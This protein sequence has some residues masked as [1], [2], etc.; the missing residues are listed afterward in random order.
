VKND[1]RDEE[2]GVLLDGAVREVAVDT[3][4]RLGGIRRRGST[5]RGV[6]WT[7]IVVA[8]A[9]FVGSIGLTAVA[10]RTRATSPAGPGQI[11]RTITI[12][13]ANG[14]LALPA[15][16]Y[17]VSAQGMNADI[18]VASTNRDA[19]DGLV[20]GCQIGSSQCGWH[21]L[22]VM[23]LGPD[24]AFV[25][26][27]ATFVPQGP[28][29]NSI[30]LLPADLRSASWEDT[31][32]RLGHPVEQVTGRGSDGGLFTI[33]RWVGPQA[34]SNTSDAL[35]G[36]LISLQLGPTPTTPSGAQADWHSY[37]DQLL[38]MSMD[39]PGW[40]DVHP[41]SGICPRHGLI[42]TLVANVPFEFQAAEDDHDRC[43]AEWNLRP[44]PPSAVVVEVRQGIPNPTG[45]VDLPLSLDDARTIPP[46]SFQPLET[47]VLTFQLDGRWWKA[48]VWFGSE[49]SDDDLASARRIIASVRAGD[50]ASTELGSVLRLPWAD[51]TL[52]APSAWYAT[53]AFTGP[54]GISV[55][56]LAATRKD[57]IDGHIRC[58]GFCSMQGVS[59]SGLEP[60]DAFL[61][62]DGYCSGTQPRNQPPALPPIIEP[63]AFSPTEDHLGVPVTSLVGSSS[64]CFVFTIR[65]WIGPEAPAGTI[66]QITKLLDQLA[67]PGS[68][69]T[70][71][72]ETIA[73]DPGIDTE[74]FAPPGDANPEI[75]ADDALAQ[76]VSRAG[77]NFPDDM[78]QQLGLYT[79]AVGDGTYRY[80]DQLA[81]GYS[82]PTGCAYAH[83]PGPSA[84]TRCV[85]WLFLDA[86]TGEMLEGLF[87]PLQ[88]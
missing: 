87:Q 31:P 70:R 56:V 67:I 68:S 72:T 22:D 86:N 43:L 83:D 5:R 14:V 55:M 29:E 47:R 54:T 24:D 64:N 33:R 58:D 30:P 39:V 52:T 6:R 10:L 65:Y 66:D 42:G 71:V 32:G 44:L 46:G 3:D 12:P 69:A 85:F 38:G 74:T 2:V 50:V 76:F 27:M 28:E 21:R 17:G 73:L 49:A 23:R 59:V 60:G 41:F 75:S 77:G 9:V 13:Y 19:L 15:G 53:G 36:I 35:D 79:A 25:E 63:R 88:P 45:S 48:T 8:L 57:V 26:V 16:W 7:A 81:W 18:L 62:V 37:T 34:G 80:Q 84:P 51:R 1:V 82:F 78:T 4:D 40:W 20:H 11:G 61:E